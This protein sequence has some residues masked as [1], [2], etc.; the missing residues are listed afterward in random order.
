M[1]ILAGRF[2]DIIS[3]NKSSFGVFSETPAGKLIWAKRIKT[4][5]NPEKYCG[6]QRQSKVPL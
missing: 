4:G 1:G 3:D 2:K 5:Q 6:F